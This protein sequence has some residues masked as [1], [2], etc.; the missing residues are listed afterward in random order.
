MIRLATASNLWNVCNIT[1]TTEAEYDQTIS[2]IK[3]PQMF[4]P[5]TSWRVNDWAPVLMD[6]AAGGRAPVITQI[7]VRCA[8]LFFVAG[9]RFE[10]RPAF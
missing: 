9:R 10:L 5:P 7:F 4:T 1:I 2:E 3:R 8:N 6:A